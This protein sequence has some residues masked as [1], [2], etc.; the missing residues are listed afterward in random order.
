LDAGEIEGEGEGKGKGKGKCSC[1]MQ[2]M[3]VANDEVRCASPVFVK[4]IQW[5]VC[6]IVGLN[7]RRTIQR[8]DSL[9]ITK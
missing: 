3:R 1:M 6:K 5:C 2:V 4:L 9:F 8:G 7:L